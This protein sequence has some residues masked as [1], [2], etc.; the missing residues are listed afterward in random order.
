MNKTYGIGIIVLI[1]I[2]LGVWYISSK[3]DV[4]PVTQVV[5][6]TTDTTTATTSVQ[7]TAS[8]KTNTFKSIFSQSGNHECLFEQVLSGYKVSSVVYIA[9]GKMRGEFRNSS[10]TTAANLMIYNGGLLYTWKEGTKVGVK[11]S[12]KTIEDLPEVI[13]K[14][15]TSGAIFG[16]SAGNVS[17]DCHAWAK[18][19][20]MFIIPSYVTFSPAV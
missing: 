5:P 1:L 13:P 3:K 11:T 6:Q 18:K 10:G 8:T 15:L 12:I 9:D 4:Q 19:D 20:S 7:T 2:A 16:T 17:W 14:D